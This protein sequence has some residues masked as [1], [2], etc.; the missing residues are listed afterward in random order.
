[1]GGSSREAA[2]PALPSNVQ[3]ADALAVAHVSDDGV[4]DEPRVTLRQCQIHRVEIELRTVEENELGRRE[5]GNLAHQLAADAAAS[6]S[7]QDTAVLDEGA[8][9]ATVQGRL[10]TAEKVLDV[11]RANFHLVGDPALEIREL[12]QARQRHARLGGAVE[13][14]AHLGPI[15]V[16]FGED[17]PLR[18][19][20]LGGELLDHGREAFRRPQDLDAVDVAAQ[21]GG[22]F[23]D[24]AD[25]PVVGAAGPRGGPD[26]QLRGVAGADQQDRD[27]A[28][29]T[30]LQA[31]VEAAVLDQAVKK[32]R[33]TEQRDQHEPVDERQGAGYLLEPRPQEHEDNEHEDGQGN[34]AGDRQQ[35]VERG[36]A[37]DS[38]IQP[39]EP[40]GHRAHQGEQNRP[41]HQPVRGLF[42]QLRAQP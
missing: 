27:A 4:A 2:Y 18:P 40:E 1:M 23:G 30:V 5:V 34:G 13:K 22:L 20:T 6:T 14:I 10:R 39:H 42:E 32:P 16:V 17:Q 36:V 11:D 3:P 38:P 37:P 31:Q 25:D 19:V 7:D 41:H 9:R 8:E 15:H 29:S 12:G 26:E 33:T 24:D 35:V 21:V 28:L